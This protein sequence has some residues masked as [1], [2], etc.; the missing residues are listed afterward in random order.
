LV[1]TVH[2][3]AV[4]DV[5]P[6]ERDVVIQVIENMNNNLVSLIEEAYGITMN[7][8]LLLEAKIGKNWL[9]VKDV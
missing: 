5:H 4:I 1:N 3:S 8:P 7:V 6:D 9:D 2:D